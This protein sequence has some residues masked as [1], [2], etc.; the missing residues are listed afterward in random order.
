MGATNPYTRPL[1]PQ[2]VCSAVT[3]TLK[4]NEID[5][6]AASNTIP[7]FYPFFAGDGATGRIFN[8]YVTA[9]AVD[10][11]DEVGSCKAGD[12]GYVPKEKPKSG[13]YSIKCPPPFVLTLPMADTPRGGA[14][15]GSTT[16]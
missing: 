8:V 3:A 12:P 11:T 9:K 13:E 14:D 1:F 5:V 10:K 6:A 2:T 7:G 15:N 4:T 16:E